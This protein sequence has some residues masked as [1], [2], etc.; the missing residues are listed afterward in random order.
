MSDSEQQ[1]LLRAT[2]APAASTLHRPPMPLRH[3]H[4]SRGRRRLSFID[5][6]RL[7]VCMLGVQFTWTVELGYGTLYLL[8]L[9]IPKSMTPL[10]WLA[11]PLSGLI[12]QPIAGAFS[13]CVD[14][15]WGRRRPFIVVGA[16]LM[17]LSMYMVA[18]ARELAYVLV[19]HW[20]HSGSS[21][22]G[23]TE[24]EDEVAYSG[25]L[26]GWTIAIAVFGFYFLDFSIN[27]VQAC[28]RFLIV[29]IPPTD[30]QEKGGAW[31]AWMNNLGSVVGFFAGNLDLVSYCSPYLGDSQI[32]IL[33]NLAV[34]VLVA[35]LGITCLSVDEVQYIPT[36]EERHR[37]AWSTL[38]NIWRAFNK[39]PAELQRICNVQFFAWMGW[40]P[41]LFYSTTWVGEIMHR[42]DER[43]PS[44]PNGD[45]NTDAER[46]GSFALL[47]WAGVSVLT[48]VLLP[49]I[50]P[51]EIGLER[52]PRNPFTLRNLWTMSMVM[53]AVC[54][55][56]TWFVDDLW[57][58]TAV[59]MLCG[60]PWAVA[61]WVPF[62][63]V[64]E[65]NSDMKDRLEIRERRAS[66]ER[67]HPHDHGPNYGTIA[68]GDEHL[69]G[70]GSSDSVPSDTMR[71]EDEAEDDS[72]VLEH[73]AIFGHGLITDSELD[74]EEASRRQSPVHLDAGLVLGVHNMYV[75]FPQ[76]VDAI[77]ASSLFA[78]L[79]SFPPQ[80]DGPIPP[81]PVPA[82]PP[83]YWP[84]FEYAGS[85]RLIRALEPEP[86]GW[87]LRFGGLMALVGAYLSRRL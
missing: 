56:L 9:G 35:C 75:V 14:W 48:G 83:R 55:G 33:A 69:H 12:I 13:D 62:A 87:V 26:K 72:S 11:G 71:D 15:K 80:D 68:S 54:M 24:V 38:G 78:L 41:F 46:A 4:S 5:L 49:R 31:S 25:A 7:T 3:Q 30:Q 74:A 18:Y 22:L 65:I 6:A 52:W 28:C 82:P 51:Q 44:P 85:L 60:V 2:K 84:G 45:P 23:F 47:C 50:T 1:S 77:V 67:L 61:L 40:F 17:V 39:L 58:A 66:Q 37:T 34:F 59:I 42:G 76:F 64:G 36:E 29:D 86:V 8:S 20:D 73:S 81:G 70:A 16:A 27:A 32:K 19:G 43:A 10:V 63:M 57:A 79:E 53:F 21:T